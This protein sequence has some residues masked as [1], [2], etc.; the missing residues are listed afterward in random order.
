[1]NQPTA[2]QRTLAQYE[3][4]SLARET[5]DAVAN[6]VVLRHSSRVRLAH[7]FVAIFF[8]L[9]LATGFVMFTPYFSGLAGWFGGGPM[10]R[11]LHPWFALAFVV[12]AFYLYIFWRAPM[13]K[14]PGD[15]EWKDNFGAYIRY[16]SELQNVGKY[17]AGQK[18][19]FWSVVWGAIALLASG[20]VM[21][22]PTSFP[23]FVRVIAY[24]LHEITFFA[25]V[26]GIIYHIY[27]STTA[28]PGTLRA[29]TRG[30]VTKDWAKWHHPRWYRE[31]TKK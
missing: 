9:S 3:I 15:E 27:M 19:Y 2:N 20:I 11:Q 12:G 26:I 18:I 28:M 8:M 31:I 24:W 6:N 23:F 30:T 4:A 17:N 1:M 29:M 16:E 13:K 22:I 25:F 7:W 14:E 10:V 5:E 21:W